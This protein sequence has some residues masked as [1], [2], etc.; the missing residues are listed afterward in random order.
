MNVASTTKKLNFNL[1]FNFV[2]TEHEHFPVIISLIL[3][4]FSIGLI[5]N[6]ENN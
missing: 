1:I 5:K 4:F 2:W 6:N 3:Y